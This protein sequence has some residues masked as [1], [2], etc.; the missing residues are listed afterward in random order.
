MMGFF[1]KK[2]KAFW[3]GL[4]LL[5]LFVMSA[6]PASAALFGGPSIPSPSSVFS[7]MERR[8]HL[9]LGSLQNQGESFN[10]AD[11]KKPS[12]EV[13]LF[14]NPSDPKAGE[15]L[16]AKAFPIYFTNSEQDLYYTWYLKHA[17]CSLG[18]SNLALCDRNGSGS[19]TVEDW[20][21]EAMQVLAQNGFDPAD[22]DYRSDSDSDGYRA[23]LGG[24]NKVSTPNH[25][26]VNDATTGKFYELGDAGD[27]SFSCPSGTSPACLQG[28]TEVNPV[29]IDIPGDG[30]SSPTAPVSPTPGTSGPAFEFVDGTV[31]HLAGLPV[32]RDNGT[33]A[34]GVGAPYCVP[35]SMQETASFLCSSGTPLASCSSDGSFS[36]SCRHLFPVAPG[37]VSGDAL[38]GAGE[39]EFWG[40]SPQDPDTADNGNKDEANV[41]G[42]GQSTFTWNYAAGDKVGV[43]VEGTSM[44]STK[45]DDS[46][47]MIMWAFS[48]NDCPIS[49]ASGTG[50]F[51][52]F[53]KGYTVTMNSANLD[54]NRCLE[55]NLVDPA[56]GGQATNLE[57]SVSAVPSAPINDE[58]EDAGGDLVVAQA[59][60]GN[61]ARSLSEVLFEWDVDL[62]NNPQFRNSG[63]LVSARVTSDL[64][65]LRLLGN[66]RG[67]ALDSVRLKL[68]IRGVDA[69]GNPILLAGRRIR[70]YL[71]GDIG[72]LRFIAKAS[73]NFSSGTIRKGRSDVIVK[74]TST[75][76][77][78]SAYR[79]DPN[80]VGE[81]M[82]V[83]L[84]DTL[85]CNDD[86]L[87]KAACRIIK[88][89]VIG[90][91]VDPTDLTNFRWTIN[92]SE[93]SCN[94]AVVS[95]DCEENAAGVVTI[96]EQNFVNFFPVSGEV[97]DSYTVTLTANDVRTG[98]TVT[99]ARTFHIIA[100][101]L[102]IESA[103]LNVAWPKLVGQYRDVDGADSVACPGGFCSEYSDS[104]FEGFSGEVVSFRAA[105]LPNFLADTSARQWT[106]DEVSFGEIPPPG[107]MTIAFSAL[108]QPPDVYNIALAAS[109][110]QSQEI[111]RALRDIWG[112]SPLDSGEIHFSAS[113]QVELREPGFAQGTLPGTKKYLAALASYV[114]TSVMFTFRILLSVILILFTTRFFLI[115]LPERLS[116]SISF[117]K[118]K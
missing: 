21:I 106:V 30:G 31:C 116:P 43:V 41:A 37:H 56:E 15:K 54:L 70:D 13:S 62:S 81:R 6:S 114:P 68:D 26:F 12:P 101:T 86:Q 32:C 60:V 42:L 45:Y 9:D 83:R 52:R 76:K 93:L 4:L 108:K 28:E 98:K 39:E 8:Y 47:S 18:G 19:I 88:N 63:A 90:L 97:G 50:T 72:Y 67:A 74:F 33:V 105:F 79:T 75:E 29:D 48:K 3:G 5:Q 14:F 36:P 22:A 1:R 27:I 109:V 100:P 53:I 89:E 110:V 46:S 51:N 78:I 20:K 57:V 66:V 107:S 82:Q 80:L 65:R 117:G 40:T 85:I 73:E 87:D 55:R 10:T 96:G 77:K 69:D 38:F 61:A 112:I 118:R 11:N 71:T 103:D 17:E 25:C 58:T 34:C 2:Q 92:G 94:R 102:S 23:R 44:I 91:R 95:V 111:R 59:S 113:S 115:L 49:L 24:D 16:S 35:D 99:L 104:V 84:S 7:D 64:Q